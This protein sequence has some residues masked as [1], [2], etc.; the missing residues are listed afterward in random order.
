MPCLDEARTVGKCVRE[1]RQAIRRAGVAGEV[2]IADN[3]SR[4]ASR[5]LARRAG[6]RVVRVRRRGYGAALQGGIA[7]ARGGWI[8]MADCDRSYDLSSLPAFVDAMRR[9]ADLAQGTRLGGTILPGAMPWTHRRLGTPF[10]NLMLF[11]CFGARVSDSQCGM[12]MFTPAAYRSLRM[13]STG[14]EFASEM[15]AKAV[16]AG[17]EVVEIPIRYRPDER[18]RPPHLHVV[19]DGLRHL[20]LILRLRLGGR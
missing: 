20:F 14:M 1:A 8:L 11:L 18:G 16:R 12:R 10:F 13:R 4:D 2:V 6:A 19:R 9:G 7:A 17:L 15:L 5:E 3:G